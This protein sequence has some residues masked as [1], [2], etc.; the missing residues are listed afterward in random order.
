MKEIDW[1]KPIE[2]DDG[3]PAIV[4]ERF[5]C[6]IYV[7]LP[8]GVQH[9]EWD[10]GGKRHRSYHTN[11]IHQLYPGKMPKVRNRTMIDYTKPIRLASRPGDS[12]RDE[13]KI[14]YLGEVAEAPGQPLL[15]RVFVP[16]S[17]GAPTDGQ[18]LAFDESG[19][20]VNKVNNGN[21]SNLRIENVPPRRSGFYAFDS[22]KGIVG[23]G[24]FTKQQAIENAPAP[25]SAVIELI[26]EGGVLID[27]IVHR[28]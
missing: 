11:G 28:G 2:L 3:T 16:F 21:G 6:T 19:V 25:P 13:R 17:S 26:D 27:A 5:S 18:S 10:D 4:I 22:Q 9:P 24:R 8:D 23:I 12:K 7:G 20:P 1:D 15:K 14:T